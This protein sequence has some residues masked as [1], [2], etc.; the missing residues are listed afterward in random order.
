MLVKPEHPQKAP[1][2]IVVTEL[3]IL[4]FIQP[5]IN[6]LSAVLIIALQLFLE[7]YTGLLLSTFITAKLEQLI[8]ASQS[9]EVTEYGIVMFVKPEHSE[10]TLEL[11]VVTEF[12]IVMLVKPEHSEKVPP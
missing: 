11:I 8:K 4:V 10:K 12:G 9:S 6:S 3:G 5:V 2:P 7:S 1:T